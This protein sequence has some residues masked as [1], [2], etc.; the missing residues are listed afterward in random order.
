MDS[1]SVRDIA[2]LL[3]DRG[4]EYDLYSVKRANRS[5]IF[6]RYCVDGP[7]KNDARV[8]NALRERFRS[9]ILSISSDDIVVTHHVRHSRV[10]ADSFSN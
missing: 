6:L 3:A 2:A 8:A 5:K 10:R 7:L 4:V 1:T 9:K